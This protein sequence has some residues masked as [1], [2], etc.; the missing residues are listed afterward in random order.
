M[1]NE[2]HHVNHNVGTKQAL[3][4]G[5]MA[6]SFQIFLCYEIFKHL[7]LILLQ[8]NTIKLDCSEINNSELQSVFA[9]YRG[10]ALHVY[11]YQTA[12]EGF[13]LF[14]S[15]FRKC[16]LFTRKSKIINLHSDSKTFSCNY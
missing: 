4:K 9:H 11:F 12:S 13:V 16:L 14:I 6:E 5:Y 1:D 2:C 10:I 7:R 8:Y 3:N 15:R